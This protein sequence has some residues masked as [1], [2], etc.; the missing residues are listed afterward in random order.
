MKIP[1][2]ALCFAVCAS[3]AH[4]QSEPASHA[5]PF[6]EFVPT[7]ECVSLQN[8]YERVGKRN[9][10]SRHFYDHFYPRLSDAEDTQ[11]AKCELARIIGEGAASTENLVR[12][13][14]E[15]N[16]Q[17]ELEKAKTEADFAKSAQDQRESEKA[18]SKAYDARIAKEAAARDVKLAKLPNCCHI[19]MTTA[20]VL[21]S[22]QGSPEVRNRTVTASHIREQWVY[23]YGKY[24]YFD[25][26]R[27]TAIQD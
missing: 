4:A 20:E 8:M 22:K 3:I 18:W 23:K 27:L 9:P 7:P 19:G 26:G 5:A 15:G 2:F 11:R 10:D 1:L 24:L 6:A 16:R 17:I 12:K 25:D 13:V 14:E 21:A